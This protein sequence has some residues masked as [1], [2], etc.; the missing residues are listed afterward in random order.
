MRSAGCLYAVGQLHEG[1]QMR[2]NNDGQI[3]FSMA[4]HVLVDFARSCVVEE[5]WRRGLKLLTTVT[6]PALTLDQAVSV[7]K[8]ETTSEIR[9]DG[10]HILVPQDQGCEKL[11][12]FLGTLAW[13][14]A[15]IFESN[16]EFYQPYAVIESFQRGD[17]VQVVKEWRERD[18]WGDIEKFIKACC[19]PY[20]HNP[21]TD[22]VHLETGKR[23]V[24][25]KRVQGPA[26][27][28]DLAANASE[29]VTAYA[30]TRTRPEEVHG[31]EFKPDSCTDPDS[32]EFFCEAVSYGLLMLDSDSTLPDSEICILREMMAMY[33]EL[34]E[35]IEDLGPNNTLEYDERGF[36]IND[37]YLTDK[38]KDAI[39]LRRLMVKVNRQAEI[40]GGFM[41][42]FPSDGSAPYVVARAPFLRWAAKHAYRTKLGELAP[43][44]NVCY[45]GLKMPNDDRNHSDW[46]V[47][48]GESI[49]S[50][51]NHEHLLNKTSTEFLSRMAETEEGG[52]I[53]LA[54]KGKVTG[55]AVFPKPNESAPPGSIAIVPHAGPAYQLA[56]TTC[57]T[58]SSG[59]VVAAMGGKLAHLAI[60]GRELDSR[61]VVTMDAM[62]RFKAGD[63][64][65]VDLDAQTIFVYNELA[66]ADSLN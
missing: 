50:S 22:I 57:C 6:T 14:T 53:K 44:K 17:A 10:Q 18:D 35:R 36:Q 34:E 61:V 24:L 41:E 7:L 32:F 60:V 12:R 42:L 38:F 3:A 16:G 30:K 28:L 20:M 29:A 5:N 47:S 51:Y 21:G 11:K 25:C 40:S 39:E 27:W 8:G 54:G 59:A 26:F 4:E 43:W 37:D 19:R 46:W 9:E 49:S 48:T 23:P 66:T 15:G 33:R 1:Y 56:M 64:I 62:T 65:T 55:V 45:T 52:C 63:L 13:Q 31:V 2:N 58:G